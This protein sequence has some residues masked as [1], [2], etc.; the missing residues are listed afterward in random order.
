MLSGCRVLRKERHFEYNSGMSTGEEK[1][2]ETLAGLDPKEVCRRSGATFD[3]ASGLYSLKS[4][5]N[6]FH[7]SPLEKRISGHSPSDDAMMKK[8]GYFFGLS[9]LG[10]LAVA[11]DVHP[12]GRLVKP[13]NMTGGQL[14][15]RGSHVLPLEKLA[16]KYG[17]DREAFLRAGTALGGD[18]SGY[19]NASLKLF[20]FPITPVTMILWTSDE[21]FP[22]R[23]DLLFDSV[24][25]FQLPVDVIWS[26]AMMSLIA[27][28]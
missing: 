22:P 18:I 11:K 28:Q 16:E 26:I 14:F 3:A 5:S 13:I 21:E 24:I 8:L 25:E 23:V 2:W 27:M 7:I 10:Y 9:L 20:P 1:I 6:N 19:G 4:F 17:D 12:G 15:F